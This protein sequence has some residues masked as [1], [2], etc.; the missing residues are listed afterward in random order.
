MSEKERDTD[1]DSIHENARRTS[2]FA[3]KVIFLLLL[4]FWVFKIIGC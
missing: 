2:A 3:C 1:D 4:I